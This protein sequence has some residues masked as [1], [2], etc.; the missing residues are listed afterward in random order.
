MP[1][2]MRLQRIEGRIRELLSEMLIRDVSDPRLG[3][4]F[5]NDVHVDRELAFAEIYVSAIE[6]QDRAPEVLEGLES[7][8][9]FLRSA[10]ASQIS[11][12]TFPRLRFHWDFTPERADKIE[13]LLTEIKKEE[14]PSGS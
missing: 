5:I 11:L 8:S 4:V 2:K 7:A 12:R 6:G 13:K 1:S 3:G 14:K 10:L 9:G